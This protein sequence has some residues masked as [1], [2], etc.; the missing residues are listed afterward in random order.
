MKHTLLA[1]IIPALILSSTAIQAA[2]YSAG[3]GIGPGLGGTFSV[4]NDLHFREGDQVQSRFELFG[5]DVDDEDDIEISGIDYKG[6]LDF[7]TAKATMDWF[8]FSGK[9]RKVFFSGGLTYTKAEIDAD[10]ELDKS[11]KIGSQQINPGDIN[12]LNVDIDQ[13]PVSP[14]LGVGWGNRIGKNSGFSFLVELG[15]GFPTSDADVKLSLND[16]NG[17]VSAADL[18]KEKD[19][20][21]DDLDGAFGM[22]SIAV[23]YHF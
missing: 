8:P 16:P 23:T 15:V 10:A 17:V 12:G 4:K 21:E 13:N 11:F 22:G 19:Q 5:F 20:L 3:I 18:K 6:D 7:T 2:D 14:Y 9:A 1:S